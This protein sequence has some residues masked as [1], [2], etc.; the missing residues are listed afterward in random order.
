MI[1][2][3]HLRKYIIR[4]ILLELGM[5][6]LAAE[7]LLVGTALTESGLRHLHQLGEGPAQG[8][9]QM[10]PATELDIWK[11]HLNTRPEREAKVLA[12]R[13]S[14][15]DPLIGNL[16]YATAMA[17]IHYWRIKEPLPDAKDAGGLA[18]YHKKYYNTHLGKTDVSESLRHFEKAVEVV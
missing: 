8:I 9:Y 13:G 7:N 6:S 10:E 12:L 4:P 3:E 17:R 15:R 1:N 18:E 11:N 14:A 5:Y 2:I 16:N